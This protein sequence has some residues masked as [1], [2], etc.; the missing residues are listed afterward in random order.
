M[1][2]TRSILT[3]R[4]THTIGSVRVLVVTPW[5]PSPAHTGSGIFNLRDA[6]LLARDHEVRVVHLIRPDWWTAETEI[7]NV[8][9]LD[10]VR[11]AYSASSV[12]SWASVRNELRQQM[13]QADVVHTMAFP[14]LLAFVGVRV[15]LP[16]VHS[17]HWG[18]L[19]LSAKGKV[20]AAA[21]LLK[22]LLRR[23]DA[24]VAVSDDLAEGLANWTRQEPQV[25]GN[26]V[27][28]PEDR[29][30]APVSGGAGMPGS[31]E[32]LRLIG[33]GGVAAHKGPLVAVMAVAA[34]E[35]CGRHASLTWVGVGPQR[36]EAEKLAV[37]LG[38]SERVHF[39]GQL[40][41]AGLEAELLQA[42]VFVLPTA[43][44]SFGV[45][46]AEALACGL[47]VVVTGDGGHLGMLRDFDAVQ[48]VERTPEAVA[49]GVL[50]V[51]EGDREN[52]RITTAEEASRKFS[53]DLRQRAYASVYEGVLEEAS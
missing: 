39:V 10:V 36:E 23:P 27:L 14:A 3:R 44:E 29:S 48:V 35:S 20:K 19:R 40:D 25:V 22:P 24:V 15:R 28:I 11:V 31:E 42:H 34:L 6:Q 12:A 43:G 30:T 33:V 9:G 26:A 2:F 4:P 37:D 49:A 53:E 51:L 5:F 1:I 7:D 8:E 41:R 52:R 50:S 38:I 18:A 47:P 16:W 45:A 32:L 13:L 46:I 17:E 21:K